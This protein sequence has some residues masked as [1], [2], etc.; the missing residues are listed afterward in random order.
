MVDPLDLG[1]AG[2]L[3]CA[4]FDPHGLRDELTRESDVDS[5]VVRVELD[6][7]RAIRDDVLVRTS[8]DANRRLAP[9]HVDDANTIYPKLPCQ[10]PTLK[11][12]RNREHGP[13]RQGATG[14]RILD[15]EV[16]ERAIF[17]RYRDAA[18]EGKVECPNHLPNVRRGEWKRAGKR[19]QREK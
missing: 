19:G 4:A 8:I 7:P 10:E 11:C 6:P 15:D 5:V 14:R 9:G 2:P 1:L 13:N 12:G 17:D 3:A 16:C 18:F